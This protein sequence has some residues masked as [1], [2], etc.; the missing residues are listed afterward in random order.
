M[1]GSGSIDPAIAYASDAETS[2]LLP[3]GR[4]RLLSH[5]CSPAA[6]VPTSCPCLTWVQWSDLRP[7]GDDHPGPPPGPQ[8]APALRRS[9]PPE[10]DGGGGGGGRGRSGRALQ[11]FVLDLMC[12]W[13]CFSYRS[14]CQG[15]TL[16]RHW[17]RRRI[18]TEIW[19]SR[20]LLLVRSYVRGRAMMPRAYARHQIS[21]G[22]ISPRNMWVSGLLALAIYLCVHVLSVRSPEQKVRLR[23]SFIFPPVSG[24]C[25]RPRTRLQ[26]LGGR[27]GLRGQST[28][29]RWPNSVS[30]YMHACMHALL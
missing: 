23:G 19:G 2:V 16:G 18:Y 11:D 13:S 10:I 15:K 14:I 28:M 25:V 24:G 21:A 20:A 3:S 30:K 7:P 4:F 27:E 8:P 6:R 26:T 22:S 5:R 1:V 17:D 12:A 9:P 29:T